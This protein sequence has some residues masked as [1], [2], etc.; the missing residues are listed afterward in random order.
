MV[1]QSIADI[2]VLRN[3]PGDALVTRVKQAQTEFMTHQG[4]EDSLILPRI[5]AV[6]SEQELAAMA[7][8]FR[9]VKQ[10][11]PLMPQVAATA[12]AGSS[13]VP[14]GTTALAGAAELAKSEKQ[15]GN[16]N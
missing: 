2:L 15:R 11:A 12:A 14:A 5:A 3:Q 9:S 1:E 4:E 16:K 8:T 7:L 13:P 6:C 10:T